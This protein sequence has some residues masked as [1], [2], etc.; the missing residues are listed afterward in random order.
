M[1]CCHLPPVS[2]TAPSRKSA[3]CH[4]AKTRVGPAQRHEREHTCMTICPPRS[5][6]G[7][8]RRESSCSTEL[9]DS[10]RASERHA[11]AGTLFADRSSSCRC[12]LSRKLSASATVPRAAAQLMD[13]SRT[14]RPLLC[15]RP[16]AIA[17]A[18]AL[19]SLQAG[20]RTVWGARPVLQGKKPSSAARRER[21]VRQSG[22]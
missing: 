20:G 21:R 16:S 5:P 4:T 19:P 7:L 18:P 9:S 14:S 10:R 6:T 15:F 22:C 2:Q 3:L 8:S 17:P 11:L 12:S 13:K 1:S